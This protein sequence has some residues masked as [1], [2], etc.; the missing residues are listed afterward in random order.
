M[1]GSLEAGLPA[2][3]AERFTGFVP[4][5][6]EALHVVMS[7]KN[8]EEAVEHKTSALFHWFFAFPLHES[9]LLFTQKK[10]VLAASEKKTAYLVPMML[11]ALDVRR[12][13]LAESGHQMP[14]FEV[15][16]MNKDGDDFE[17]ELKEFLEQAEVTTC[18]HM[19]KEEHIG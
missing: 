2:A 14:E 19:R 10:V 8:D 4:T 9:C 15:I 16:A 18:L 5:T 1:R 3:F 6:P 12:K 13:R 7:G 11:K 17:T